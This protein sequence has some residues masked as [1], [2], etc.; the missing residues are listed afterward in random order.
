MR[1]Y[2]L[3]SY[4]AREFRKDFRVP[5]PVFDKIYDYVQTVD[6]LKDKPEGHGNGRGPPRV[7]ASIKLM[8]SLYLLGH[9][10]DSIYN[11]N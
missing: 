7:P 6:E 5:R 10:C 2:D 11:M 9:G 8:A 1:T 3:K 4:T